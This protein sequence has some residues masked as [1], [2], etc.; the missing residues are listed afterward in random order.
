[1]DVQLNDV[2]IHSIA[3]ALPDNRLDLR[4]LDE[5]FGEDEVDRMIELNGI[6]QVRIAPEGMCTSDFCEV[7]AKKL[8]AIEDV[9]GVDGVVFVSQTPD[10][11]LPTTGS[12]LQHRL[13]LSQATVT[14]DINNGCPGYV[15]GLYQAALLIATGS[16]NAVLVCVG[17]VITPYV[18][19]LD[20]HARMVFGDAGSATLVTKG[21]GSIAFGI[22]TDGAKAEHL[23][24]PAGGCRYPLDHESG[25]VS[26]QSDGSMR[27]DE[28]LY[29]NG[30]EVMNHAI[31][32]IPKTIEGLFKHTGWSQS[33]VG[34]F[35]F[36]QVNHF[37][38]ER[39]RKIMNLPKNKIP[40]TMQ[41]YGNT[42]SASIPLMLTQEH[43]RLASEDRLQKA[44][45]CGFGVGLSCA[46]TA[47][48]LS[49]TKIWDTIEI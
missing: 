45:L 33:E 24:I 47:L 28:D 25:L 19:P 21:N 30:M 3:C 38:L 36:H 7:A 27:S 16:C 12:L 32:E 5:V 22:R 40:V 9:S 4:Q 23:I 15:Y 48:D 13:G 46:G 2:V 31:Q 35:G 42:G 14:F 18:N 44:M 26:V 1:M 11:I 10:Y 41:R 37:M 20:K 39:L 8:L 34:F 6:H 43:S 29:M 49:Q 17:D